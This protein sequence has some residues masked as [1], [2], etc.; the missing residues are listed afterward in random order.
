MSST[1]RLRHAQTGRVI[2][3]W[4]HRQAVRSRN[5]LL[6]GY[7]GIWLDITR[8]TIAERRL[9]TLAWKESM[10]VLTMGLTHDF[11]NLLAGVAAHIWSTAPILADE[12]M[13]F[14]SDPP[15]LARKP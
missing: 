12:L 5:G 6:L 13:S 10:G 7:E 14:A 15:C 4:E 11:T 9:S 8:Q 2:Y 3:V 1:F